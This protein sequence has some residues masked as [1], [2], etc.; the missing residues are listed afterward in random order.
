MSTRRA[1]TAA[2]WS[3]LVLAGGRSSRMGRDKAL[4]DWHGQP[5]LLHMRALLLRAGAEAVVLS[6]DYPAHGG[7]A[8]DRPG[9]GPMAGL[10]QRAPQLHDGDWLIVPVDMPLL[11]PELLH[12]LRDAAGDCASCRDHPLPMRLR[13]DARTRP[14][15]ARVGGASDRACSLRALQQ[16]LAAAEID[17]APWR[18]QLANC[19]TAEEWRTLSGD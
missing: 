14:I 3:A 18:A 15:I 9:N 12:A 5:L 19:N 13:L 4:L 17:D 6:G 8:D 11:T 2:A 7:I 1:G 10:A 16:A